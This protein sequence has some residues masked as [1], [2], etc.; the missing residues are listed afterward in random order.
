MFGEVFKKRYCDKFNTPDLKKAFVG[1]NCYSGD[2]LI[3]VKAD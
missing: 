1:D 2:Q 3:L